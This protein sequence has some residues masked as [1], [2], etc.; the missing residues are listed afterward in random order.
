MDEFL[1]SP[2]FEIPSASQ[3]NPY[4]LETKTEENVTTDLTQSP[5]KESLTRPIIIGPNYE[6]DM[7]L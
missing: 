3:I 6:S 1:L 7:S 4:S 2:C 5:L